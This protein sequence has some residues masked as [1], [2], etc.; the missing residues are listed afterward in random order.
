MVIT[1]NGQKLD[2]PETLE[3]LTAQIFT[4]IPH[5]A[6]TDQNPKSRK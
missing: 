2:D 5:R 6:K 4:I 1:S 3:N